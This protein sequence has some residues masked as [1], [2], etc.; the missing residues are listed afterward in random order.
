[1]YTQLGGEVSVGFFLVGG[2]CGLLVGMATDS[3]VVRRHLSRTKLFAAVVLLG[4][5][6]CVGTYLCSTYPQLLACRIVTGIAVG[7]A[8]PIIYRCVSLHV[9]SSVHLSL[10]H[11]LTLTLTPPLAPVTHS[12]LGDLWGASSRVL[13][14]T[15]VGLSMSFGA[16]SGQVLAAYLA[17]QYVLSC[18]VHACV[19]VSTCY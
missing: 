10:S 14:A 11:A 13:V 18:P 12:I 8:S 17:P 3:T 7:G 6:G 5:S 16:A 2:A 15:L 19:Y 1:M 9:C 4:E